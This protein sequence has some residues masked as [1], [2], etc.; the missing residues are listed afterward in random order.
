MRAPLESIVTIIGTLFRPIYFEKYRQMVGFSGVSGISRV[1]T[2][3]IN[4]SVGIKVRFSF[5]GAN[6]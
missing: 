3:R 5:I 1:S 4:V 2:V 6:L